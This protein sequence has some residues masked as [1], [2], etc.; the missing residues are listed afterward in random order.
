[1]D[2]AHHHAEP[3][4]ANAVGEAIH[5]IV[6]GAGPLASAAFLSEIYK[7]CDVER[8]QDMPRILLYSDPSFPDRSANLLAGKRA[9]LAGRLHEAVWGLSRL[10]ATDIVVCCFTLHDVIDEL[11]ASLRSLVISLI[12]VTFARLACE[13]SA[14]VLLCTSASRELGLFTRHSGWADVQHLVALPDFA[15]QAQIHDLIYDL[16]VG[17]DP[18]SLVPALNALMD[19]HGVRG[20]IVGCTEIHLVSPLYDGHPRYRYVDALTEIR[21]AFVASAPLLSDA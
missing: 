3:I 20:F 15:E 11:P 5:G 16:K 7:S 13:Q 21:K 17:A 4:P 12:D 10:G 18:A 1:M 9:E 8:E 19:R 6:G 14:A 2:N